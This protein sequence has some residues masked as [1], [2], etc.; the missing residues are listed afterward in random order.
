MAWLRH[1]PDTD[2]RA[3]QRRLRKL[4]MI[5][6]DSPCSGDVR[7]PQICCLPDCRHSGAEYEP[8]PKHP[9]RG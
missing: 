1:L 4:Q 2:A 6:H 7:T 8:P 5:P 3:C 9:K